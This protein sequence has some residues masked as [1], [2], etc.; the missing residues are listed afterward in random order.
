MRSQ[1]ER[2]AWLYTIGLRDDDFLGVQTRVDLR[3]TLKNN[4]QSD[5]WLLALDVEQ[6]VLRSLTVNVRA[7]IF[8]GQSLDRL[9]ERGRTFDEAQRIFL[10]GTGIYWRP[11]RTHLLALDYDGIYETELLDERTDVSLFVHTLMFRYGYYF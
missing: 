2:D 6:D 1:D 5:S 4:F 9:T 7:T 3:A 8:D 11:T 10:M